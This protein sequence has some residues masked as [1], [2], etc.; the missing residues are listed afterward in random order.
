M[1]KDVMTVAR[2]QGQ[3]LM[4]IGAM[5]VRAIPKEASPKAVVNHQTQS[6]GGL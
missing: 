2:A 5:N 6:I 4:K 3:R 1:T